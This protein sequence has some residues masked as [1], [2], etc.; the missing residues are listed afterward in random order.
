MGGMETTM[1]TRAIAE[2]K[3]EPL[4]S[5]QLDRWLA[6]K[7][8]RRVLVVPFGGPIPSP[9]AP[10]GVDLDNE[11]FSER[12]D[13]FGDYVALRSSRARLVDWH[14]DID[15]TGRMKGA[16]L[17][18]VILDEK[19]EDDGYWADFWANAG[20][21][22]LALVKK[23]EERGANLYGSSQAVSKA[24]D[25]DTGEITYWPLI[26][27][28]ITTSPQNILAVVPP[29]KAMLDHPQLAEQPVEALAALL[30]GIADDL[31]PFDRST[32]RGES[33]SKAGRVL[34][35]RNWQALVEA[36][37]SFDTA[38]ERVRDVLARQPD[39]DKETDS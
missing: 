38:I 7:M 15:P 31:A 25:P 8:P 2:M 34:S 22:R 36:L 20:E 13:L 4:S 16:I 18:R 10:R 12:T 26:R 39:Y 9:K 30:A 3:A 28:T 21:Q 17:G 33:G 37:D 5:T 32:S 1:P 19:A 29:L 14:H 23:L 27:H 24:T 11:W 35:A 6:G